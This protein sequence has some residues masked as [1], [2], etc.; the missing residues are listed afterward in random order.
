MR[1]FVL[2]MFKDP[3]NQTF[4]RHQAFKPELVKIMTE[5]NTINSRNFD[6][7]VEKLVFEEGIVIVDNGAA[8]F[9]PLI[10]YIAEN[11]NQS[12]L[13]NHVYVPYQILKVLL[14]QHQYVVK[15]QG[16]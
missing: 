9:V 4:L 7:L 14:Q 15:I 5:H 8:T 10:S 2:L 6:G 11:Y 1:C 13:F 16:Q 3:V 12:Y